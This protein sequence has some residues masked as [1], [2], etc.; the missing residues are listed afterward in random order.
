MGI[1]G[2]RAAPRDGCGPRNVL[3]VGHSGVL[4]MELLAVRD[5]FAAATLLAVTGGGW[6]DRAGAAPSD[7]TDPGG[8]YASGAGPPPYEVTVCSLGG[9]PLDIGGGLTIGGVGSL[10]EHTGPVDTL[11]VIGGLVAPDVAAT[12]ADLVETIRTVAG[13]SRRVVSTCS[14]AFLLAAAGVLDGRRATTHWYCG[15]RLQA[16]HPRIEVDTDAIYVRDGHVWTSAGVTAAHDLVLALIEEDLGPEAALA[17]ARQIVVYLRRAG[18]QTQFSIQLAAPPARRQRIREVQDHIVA[19]PGVDLSLATLASRVHLSPRHF[20]RLF[21]TEVG[22]S[23][24]AYVERV[25]LEAARRTVEFTDLPLATVAADTGFGTGENLRR[26]F[27]SELGVSP[28]EY[29]RRFG[30]RSV[31][32]LPA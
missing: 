9:E 16:E 25:R 26:V 17:V 13:R 30:L 20:A 2:R 10:R 1:D 4:G 18:G 23:P 21:S 31:E 12:D 22:M 14:G 5:M 32:A 8:G 28:A 11:A 3:V 24:G 6:P 7:G 19:N 15:E 27:V 29:R